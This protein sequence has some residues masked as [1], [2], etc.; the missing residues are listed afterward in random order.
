M[1]GVTTSDILWS[2]AVLFEL[3]I[4]TSLYYHD[5]TRTS[6]MYLI[7]SVLYE[8]DTERPILLST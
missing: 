3:Q 1:V 7:C 2:A 5:F 4:F 6:H 8:A